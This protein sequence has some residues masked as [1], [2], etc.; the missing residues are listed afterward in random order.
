VEIE[1]ARLPRLVHH[2]VAAG[3][4]IR[5]SPEL[6]QLRRGMIDLYVSI[7]RSSAPAAG[8]R[9]CQLQDMGG[10][11]RHHRGS[12]RAAHHLHGDG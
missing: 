11:S 1:A 3:M 6:L 10:Q 7:I 8:G 4:K 5:T 12:Y 2:T 9:H